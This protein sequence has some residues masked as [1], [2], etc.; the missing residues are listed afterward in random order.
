MSGARGASE[1]GVPGV[2]RRERQILD[3]LYRLGR[4]SVREVQ[5]R[6]HDAPT[7][8]TVRK[9]LEV[10]ETKGLVTHTVRGKA[11]VYSPASSPVAARRSALRHLVATFFGGSAEAAAIALLEDSRIDAETRRRLVQRIAHTRKEGR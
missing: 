10:M 5:E 11:Y 8:S 3:A 7:Y 6:L 4:G 2:S 1:R 9:L